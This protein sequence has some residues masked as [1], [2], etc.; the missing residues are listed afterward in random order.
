MLNN[1]LDY[2][3]FKDESELPAL[4][5]LIEKDLSEP[6]SIYTYRY[7]IS[8]WPGLCHLV[9]DRRNS[10]GLNHDDDDNGGGRLVGVIIGK[11]AMHRCSQR[12]RG[13]I[14]MLAVH[15]DYRKAGIGMVT[16]DSALFPL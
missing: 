12:M 10:D 8:N 1:F 13:Y 14:A 9:Y 11:M 5:R 7:F 3:P 6:Y 2:R 4:M 15:K 16:V